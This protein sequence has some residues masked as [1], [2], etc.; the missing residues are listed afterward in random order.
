MIL[1]TADFAAL[2][3]CSSGIPTESDNFPPYFSISFTYSTGTEDDPCRTIGYPGSFF[4]IS[5]RISNASGGGIKTPSSLR[6]HC[7]GLNF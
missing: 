1:Q 6:V 2:R 3:S 7:S 5:S 4:S